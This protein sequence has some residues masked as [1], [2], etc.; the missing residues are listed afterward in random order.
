M[1][2]VLKEDLGSTVWTLDHSLA[3]ELKLTAAVGA[4]L[5]ATQLRR[6]D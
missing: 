4:R 3:R 2:R 6:F 1:F 5:P